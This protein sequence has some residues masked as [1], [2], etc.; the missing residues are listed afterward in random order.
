MVRSARLSAAT[1]G[2]IVVDND[3]R[4][5]VI[6]EER[7]AGKSV[8]VIAEQYECTTS[9]VDA[10]IDRRLNFSTTTCGSKRLSSMLR[11]SKG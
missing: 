3:D 7:I 9:E 5:G 2:F 6:L 4:D 8:V 11:G 1:G 10:A